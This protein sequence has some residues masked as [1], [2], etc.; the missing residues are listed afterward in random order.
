M[1]ALLGA[2]AFSMEAFPGCPPSGEWGYVS[3]QCN[4]DEAGVDQFRDV[5][6]ENIKDTEGY[7]GALY[8]SKNLVMRIDRAGFLNCE[9]TSIGG[10][11]YMA[12]LWKVLT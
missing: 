9:T 7:G 2:G 11:V 5:I 6:F 10:A 8:T 1:L 3:K 12:G 4:A